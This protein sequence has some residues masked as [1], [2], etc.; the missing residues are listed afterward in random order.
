[1]SLI[2]CPACTGSNISIFHELNK[3][4]VNSC[5][6]LKSQQEALAFPTGKIILT[7]CHD[8]GFIFNQAFDTSLTEYSS[9]YE[10]TQRFS[11]TFNTF[12]DK[13]I[14][15]LLNDYNIHNKHVIE[16][17]C[18]KGE[19]LIALCQIGNNKGIGFDPG[20]ISS[21]IA[22]KMEQYTHAHIE[23]IKDFYSAKYLHHQA[24][25]YCCKMTL[26]H[27]HQPA[28]ILQTIRQSINNNYNARVFIQVPN[29]E[30]IINECAFEDIYYEHCNYFTQ[31]SLNKILE[32]NHFSVIENYYEYDN[33]YLTLIAKP[34]PVS[35]LCKKTA[36]ES[37]TPNFQNFHQRWTTKKQTWEQ[38]LR[39][40]S[41][42][43]SKVV[44]WGGGSKAVSFLTSLNTY[45]I[46]EFV[47]DINP[48][49]QDSYLPTTGQRIVAPKF[50]LE[51]KPDII[52]IMNPVYLSEISESLNAMNL[53]PEILTL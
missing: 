32:L 1:M 12:Q 31:S 7:T 20:F 22:S 15:R 11:P 51:Y 10:E 34:L 29:A 43:K 16:I 38:L 50:L 5:L 23:F 39:H 52:V 42:K 28:L 36:K 2:H 13:L 53:K 14:N 48:F 35:T 47:V 17:G 49:R 26:E 37:S 21:R 33:Q 8:C 3:T 9:L 30:R 44:L 4:P 41:E 19:F 18:G 24:D 45:E 46:I 25:L 6:L 27:I 40:W